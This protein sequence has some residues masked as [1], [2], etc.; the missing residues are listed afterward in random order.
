MIRYT[1]KKIQHAF[2]P[3]FNN[4]FDFIHAL[5]RVINSEEFVEVELQPGDATQIESAKCI[6][7]QQEERLAKMREEY[8][9]EAIDVAEG[10]VKTR[11]QL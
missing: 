5:A 4:I 3:A 11:E 6:I 2:D 1:S 9:D 8:G 7:E 10:V